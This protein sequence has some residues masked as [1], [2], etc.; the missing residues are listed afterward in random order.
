VPTPSFRHLPALRILSLRGNA[1][2]QLAAYS[3]V[4]LPLIE[5]IDLTACRLVAVDRRAFVGCRHLADLS[6]AANSLSRLEAAEHLPGPGVLRR[7]R[8][9]ANPWTCDCRLR[10]LH[11]RLRATVQ[12]QARR[13]EEP[14]CDAPRLLRGIPWRQLSRRQFACASRIVASGDRRVITASPGANVTVSCVVVGDPA[15]RVRWSRGRPSLALPPS[16]SRRRYDSGS[17]ASDVGGV[18][19]AWRLV[20]SLKLVGVGASDAGEYRCT[21]EN[22][23]GRAEMMYTVLV[24]DTELARD[25]DPE[26]RVGGRTSFGVRAAVLAGSA[27]V[28]VVAVSVASCA[29]AVRLRAVTRRRPGSGAVHW[30]SLRVSS[31]QRGPG[32]STSVV[33][34]PRRHPAVSVAWADGRLTP[35]DDRLKDGDRTETVGHRQ[36]QFRMRI[37]PAARLP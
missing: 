27:T 31:S 18:A 25:S 13:H 28:A 34:T 20:S 19:G 32:W 16:V 4:D 7:L 3:F 36:H 1:L 21:A 26:S 33:G 30:R 9:D 37:F 2:V 10:W 23:A 12:V 24:N 15:P 5:S 6:I 35:L 11:D 22:A 17:T 29:V 14:V 8:V